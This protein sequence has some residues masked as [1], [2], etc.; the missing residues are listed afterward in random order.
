MSDRPSAEPDAAVGVLD[1]PTDSHPLDVRSAAELCPFLLSADRDWRSVLPTREHRCTAV[2]PVAV[3]SLDKQRRLC[4][5]QDH[6]ACATYL[7]A[8]ERLLDEQ[9]V[10][11]ETN[12]SEN[13]G[14]RPAIERP[15]LRWAV[16]RTAPV[17][18]DRGRPSVRDILLHRST[19]QLALVLL[20]ALAFLVLALAR[21]SADGAGSLSMPSGT[22]PATLMPAATAP[23]VASSPGAPGTRSAPAGT[24]SVP[25]VTPAPGSPAPA[26]PALSP[27]AARTYRVVAGDTLTGIAARYGVTLK[28]L[29]V[30]NGITDPSHLRVGTVLKIP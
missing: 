8:R 11:D 10:A 9:G 20:M 5:T 17:V 2:E 23:A 19:T 16:P 12:A 27:S 13:G 22:A 24:A 26:S 1:S 7:A 18:L 21:L 6:G 15:V 3:L 14:R 4:L 28:A 30:A 29:E 25:A